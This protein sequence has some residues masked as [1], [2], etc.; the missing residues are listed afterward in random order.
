MGG[1]RERPKGVDKDLFVPVLWPILP[2]HRP[3]EL[4]GVRHFSTAVKVL[5]HWRVIWRG[6]E[7]ERYR[8][9]GVGEGW[10]G[11]L[12]GPRRLEGNKRADGSRLT[13]PTP[14]SVPALYY[15][16]ETT[17]LTTAPQRWL[18]YKGQTRNDDNNNNLFGE[19]K[20]CLAM[21]KKYKRLCW[22]K[23]W[24]HI[25]SRELWKL[26]SSTVSSPR[27]FVQPRDNFLQVLCPLIA[28]SAL[29]NLKLLITI[30][31]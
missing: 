6:R 15:R 23:T 20:K 1:R 17:A 31:R 8:V 24:G 25:W 21:A 16:W 28:N 4:P 3:V 9:T 14:P 18:I 10:P 7:R 29:P 12:D 13:P 2:G 11:L 19:M 27:S 30:Q 26:M 22:K 5:R